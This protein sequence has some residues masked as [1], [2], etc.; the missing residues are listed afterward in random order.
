ML[1][2]FDEVD[3]RLAAALRA[4]YV[5]RQAEPV[6]PLPRGVTVVLAGHRAAGK[7]RLLPH[8]ARLL[9]RE[10]VDLDRVLAAR[11]GRPLREWVAADEPGFRRAEVDFSCASTI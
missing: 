7:T 6:E 1:S 4:E 5:R 8:V 9:G 10:A 11:A 3:H 2:L